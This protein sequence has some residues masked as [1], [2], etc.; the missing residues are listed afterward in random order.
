MTAYSRD[1]PF[2]RVDFDVLRKLSCDCSGIV[3][4]DDKYEMFYSRLGKHVRRLGLNDFAEYC[5]LLTHG[6]AEEFTQFINS[7]TTNLTSFFRESHHFDYLRETVI[8]ELMQK[9]AASKKIRIW[10]AGC[11][12]GEEPYSLAMILLESLPPGWD[13]KILATDLDTNVL[14]VAEDGIYA[15][16]RVNGLDPERLRRWFRK[17][18]GVQSGNV[19]VNES[20]RSVVRFAPL[21]LMQS[22]PMR[23]P[24][25]VIFCR[26]VLIYFDHDTKQQLVSG[27]TRYLSAGGWLFIG[28]S[29][30]LYQISDQYTLCG[31]TIYRKEG[32]NAA[33]ELSRKIS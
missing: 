11:S 30:S 31:N 16:D 27:F 18:K 7:I 5:E 15:I 14:T 9:N 24:F 19:C 32:E 28:H 20:L 3:V 25:D 29:E 4:S 13:L 2:S 8:P 6:H 23:G 33:A 26:N 21:N 10:S 22:W 12:T 1:I 17:G